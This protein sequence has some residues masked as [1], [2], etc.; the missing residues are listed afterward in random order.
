MFLQNKK[1]NSTLA[2]RVTVLERELVKTREMVQSDMKK[3]IEI[4]NKKGK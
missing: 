1:T 3:L 4:I 2:D